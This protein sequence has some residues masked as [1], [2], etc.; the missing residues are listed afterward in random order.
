[1]KQPA[2]IA[3]LV[4]FITASSGLAAPIQP[5]VTKAMAEALFVAG[6]FPQAKGTYSYLLSRSPRDSQAMMRVGQIDLYANELDAAK[7]MLTKAIV[8]NPN[9]TEA[10]V[11]LAET[12]YRD[13]D[14]PNAVKALQSAGSAA[15]KLPTIASYSTLIL[16]KL[17]SF[18]TT[19]PYAI[20]APG[21][22][23]VLKFIKT[24]PLP[25]VHVKVDGK[26]AVFF[27]DTGGDEVIVDATLAKELHV[28]RYANRKA[29]FA[30]GQIGTV[31]SG[32]IA[33]LTLGD[34]QVQ[35]VPVQIIDTRRLSSA[36]GVRI[37]GCLGTVILSH[38]LATLDY[39]NGRLVL[40]PKTPTI[41]I[42]PHL[43]VGAVTLPFWL[44]GDHQIV[45]NGSVNGLPP[46]LFF[47]DSGM[48]SGV[49]I[50]EALFHVAGIQLDEGQAETGRAGGGASYRIVPYTVATA[51]LG[52]WQERNVPGIFDGPQVAEDAFG[53]YTQGLIGHKF[54][55]PHSV[56]FDF[57]AM[58]M[59]I[60]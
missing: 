55:K 5:T 37:D 26:D 42:S 13:D 1:M 31:G 48:T 34:W 49:N 2:L 16:D 60:Q 19:R 38:F 12:Y 50:R 57:S 11:L 22:R 29:L 23:T 6:Q 56:T 39:A 28:P 54:F 58:R 4:I 18:G 47:I 20:S 24:D 9:A 35:Q 17:Q 46:A 30:G 14:F 40:Q 15:A 52:G 44:T 43:S 33:S 10:K 51:N 27:I 21:Q 41:F 59:L 45:A 32:K 53:F 36:F 3:S 7:T 8:A 25:I